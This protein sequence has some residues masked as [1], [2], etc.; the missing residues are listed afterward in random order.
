MKSKDWLLRLTLCLAVGGL[1]MAGIMCLFVGFG[2]S[3]VIGK[4]AV[5]LY[6]LLQGA[7][8]VVMRIRE[9]ALLRSAQAPTPS[10]RMRILRLS[11]AWLW[12]LGS[13][14]L[15]ASM[16][17]ALCG[18]LLSSPPVVL[19]CWIGFFA[20][21]IGWLGRLMTFHRARQS[22]IALAMEKE[23]LQKKSA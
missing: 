14:T 15:L 23:R 19:T 7:N 3:T 11:A 21:L 18:M 8:V 17:F 10:K 6:W 13:V 2:F 9:A 5:F 16:V 1:G 20:T 4:E 22:S 12:R